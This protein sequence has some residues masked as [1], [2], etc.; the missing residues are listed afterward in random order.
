M[1]YWNPFEAN[2]Y[3]NTESRTCIFTIFFAKTQEDCWHMK[4]F[5]Y[6]CRPKMRHDTD[7]HPGSVRNV[8]KFGCLQPQ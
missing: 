8:E 1:H 5:F 3:I 2:Q 6:L 4:F 7:L